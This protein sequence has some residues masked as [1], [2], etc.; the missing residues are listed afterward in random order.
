MRQTILSKKENGRENEERDIFIKER[1]RKERERYFNFRKRNRKR[2]ERKKEVPVL[3]KVARV[4]EELG[5]AIIKTLVTFNLVSEVS[6]EAKKPFKAGLSKKNIFFK[7]EDE[8][9]GLS[10]LEELI[11]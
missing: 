3:E 4:K 7:A 6:A 2:E 10:F 1:K 11:F 9:P 8:K 5:S